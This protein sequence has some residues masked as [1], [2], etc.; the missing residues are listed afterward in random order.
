MR[1]IIKSKLI[2]YYY[3]KTDQ[4]AEFIMNKNTKKMRNTQKPTRDLC[5]WVCLYVHVYMKMKIK[6]NFYEKRK[7][8]VIQHLT[9]NTFEKCW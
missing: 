2:I 9:H 8:W 3:T 1:N 5:M 7:Y 6:K 4:N